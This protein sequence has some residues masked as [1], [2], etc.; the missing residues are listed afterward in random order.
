MKSS[1]KKPLLKTNNI[2]IM[3]IIIEKELKENIKMNNKKFNKINNNNK[4]K[5]LV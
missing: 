2:K 5:N 4:I 1:K 3:Q